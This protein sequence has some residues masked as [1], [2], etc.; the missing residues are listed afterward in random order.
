[1]LED[2]TEK[3]AALSR[4]SLERVQR[5]KKK[6]SCCRILTL[7]RAHGLLPSATA[8]SPVE[9]AFPTARARAELTTSD[10]LYTTICCCQT[11]KYFFFTFFM[12]ANGSNRV[13]VLKTYDK[14][15]A[16]AFFN[17]H[18]TPQCFF[19][20]KSH[21]RAFC[22]MPNTEKERH[23]PFLLIEWLFNCHQERLG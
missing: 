13:D 18:F 14:I 17:R 22:Y 2:G 15:L 16:S 7:N 21:D 5:R 20:L 10:H 19:L 6:T 3:F 11:T 4:S 12:L 1:M 8:P 9:R 23:R